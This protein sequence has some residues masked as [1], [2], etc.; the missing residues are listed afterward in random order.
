MYEKEIYK[1][2]NIVKISVQEIPENQ[3]EEIVV[4]CHE[5][6]ED[7]LA[8]LHRIKIS[9]E[10]L[11]VTSEDEI[12]QIALR[13]IFYF[14]TVDNKSFFYCRDKVYET[15]LKLY[16]FEDMTQGSKFFRATKSTIINAL[17]ISYIK[18]SIS[19]RFE[20]C[21]EN[22]ERLLVS[23]QYVPDLKRKIGL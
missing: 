22:G 16:E 3:E 15:K 7:I 4:K 5:I 1:D 18:P 11:V 10:K 23:R 20:V 12:H 8:L 19:G 9:E 14:E 6:N 17:K 13:D 2:G 21:M